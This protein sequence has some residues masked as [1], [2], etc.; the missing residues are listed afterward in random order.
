MGQNM[1]HE[2]N[3]GSEAQCIGEV[4]NLDGDG[5]LTS[6]ELSYLGW[7]CEIPDSRLGSMCD[8]M[9]KATNMFVNTADPGHAN[10]LR[11]TS[12]TKMGCAYQQYAHPNNDKSVGEWLCD[13]AEANYHT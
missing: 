3:P 9:H 7:L 13:F 2:L 6:F 10:I 4:D 5:T 12:Y 1:T 11:T 8:E